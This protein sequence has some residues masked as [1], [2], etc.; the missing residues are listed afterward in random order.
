MKSS[1]DAGLRFTVREDSTLL[2]YLFE[3]FPDEGKTS[4]K[5]KLSL[6]QFLVNG[7]T[8]TAFDAV[9]HKGD[10]ILML[11]KGISKARASRSDVKDAVEKEGVTIVYEDD[12]ILIADK[13]SGLLTISTAN[14][15]DAKT[16]KREKTLYAILNKYVKV[17]ASSERKEDLISGRTPDRSPKKI[18]IVHR[19]DRGTSGLLVFAKDERTKQI[20]QS[21]W[22]ELIIERTY[23]AYVEGTLE[24]ASGVVQSY[25][26]ENPKSLYVTSS[27]TESKESKLAITHY[28][29]KG[30]VT[31]E[32][33]YNYSKVE[34]SLTTGRK[35]QIRVHSAELGHPIAG[36][37][38][39]GAET[40]P[41]S[42]IALHAGTLVLRDPYSKA[43]IRTKSPLP[44]AFDRFEKKLR[45]G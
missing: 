34:Y 37:G 20:L 43:V 3:L 36:D 25:L 22:K 13:P 10:T 44:R 15:S 17:S 31:L 5:K 32:K 18:W 28:R 45:N 26:Y 2:K 40:D 27:D 42:R 16:S 11:P 33:K 35:H 6:G 29:C 4:V 19:I 7:R 39:Y 1:N 24:N 9:L 38:I 12:H 8:E 23:T 21:R 41:I 14:G 30:F